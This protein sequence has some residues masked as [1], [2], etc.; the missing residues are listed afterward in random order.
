MT[1]TASNAS[2]ISGFS[3]DDIDDENDARN[4]VMTNDAFVN[5]PRQ[6]GLISP[7]V[8]L[9]YLQSGGLVQ[10]LFF[11]LASLL[12]EG[13]KV[14]MDFLLRDWSLVTD[15]SATRD[16]CY[17]TFYLRNLRMFVIS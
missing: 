9:A 2:G 1:S 11:L 8:Y 13:S 3:D 17:K 15:Q 5:E 6:Y 16:Q 10:V 7:A 4:V 14:Y 12:F